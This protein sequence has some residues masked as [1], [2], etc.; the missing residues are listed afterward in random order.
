MIILTTVLASFVMRVTGA[1]L[2]MEVLVQMSQI[3]LE[4][5]MVISAQEASFVKRNQ[6]DPR[7]VHLAITLIQRVNQV[8]NLV[9]NVI[10]VQLSVRN[11]NFVQLG[12]IVL[13]TLSLAR[14]FHAR[15][16]PTTMLAAWHKRKIVCLVYQ[17]IFAQMGQ[18]F[19]HNCVILEA[20]ARKVRHHQ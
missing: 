7:A 10:F 14:N 6:R 8:A 15:V 12:I 19:L 4:N 11:L 9:Q 1:I 3:L 13:Q 16:E 2:E 18:A 17:D 20:F 5:H